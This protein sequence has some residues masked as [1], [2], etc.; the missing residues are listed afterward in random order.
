MNWGDPWWGMSSLGDGAHKPQRSM[1]VRRGSCE[2]QAWHPVSVALQGPPMGGRVT[3]PL[4]C[5][6]SWMPSGPGSPP[7]STVSSERFHLIFLII[8]SHSAKLQ[9]NLNDLIP[10]IEHFVQ[11]S[12]E[13]NKQVGSSGRQLAGLGHFGCPLTLAWPMGGSCPAR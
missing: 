5:C 12:R 13:A 6:P 7:G 8:L 2:Q 3:C 10:S 1:L 9:A 11:V 4:S